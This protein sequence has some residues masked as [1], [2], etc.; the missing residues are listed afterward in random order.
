MPWPIRAG[1]PSRS[2]ERS[3]LLYLIIIFLYS[4]LLRAK[5]NRI[6]NVVELCNITKTHDNYLLK[7]ISHRHLTWKVSSR[8]CVIRVNV[9]HEI[10]LFLHVVAGF[11]RVSS[12]WLDFLS[13]VTNLI[14]QMDSVRGKDYLCHNKNE[15]CIAVAPAL[16]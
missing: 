7:S 11:L 1:L 13:C 10:P 2:F 5:T 3:L 8:P 6:P 14:G 9:R 12:F 15:T 4:S 16:V